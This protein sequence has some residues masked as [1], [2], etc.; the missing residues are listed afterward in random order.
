MK[1][2]CVITQPGKRNPRSVEDRYIAYWRIY[3]SNVHYLWVLPYFHLCT[4]SLPCRSAS[5]ELPSPDSLG[6]SCAVDLASS[7]SLLSLRPFSAIHRLVLRTTP[8]F[9][10][11]MLRLSIPTDSE[12]VADHRRRLSRHRH[13]EWWILHRLDQVSHRYRWVPSSKAKSNTGTGHSSLR[14][15]YRY[16]RRSCSRLE[17]RRGRCH[18]RFLERS[19]AL[20][21]NHRARESW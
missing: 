11:P 3:E 2:S 16:R 14:S 19:R 17:G 6:R 12:H 8:P 15:N 4:W 9:S 20:G 10:K 7:T 13:V 1:P 5:V 18:C 21:Y